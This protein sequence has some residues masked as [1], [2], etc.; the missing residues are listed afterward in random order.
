MPEHA[1][2]RCRHL[3]CS[4]YTTSKFATQR[5]LVVQDHP[6]IPVVSLEFFQTVTPAVPDI[7]LDAVL[8][9]LKEH[10]SITGSGRMRGFGKNDPKKSGRPE[11][12]T[13]AHV[14][15]LTE[16]I[17]RAGEGYTGQESCM[18]IE[19]SPNSTPSSQRGNSSRPDGFG[20][21]SMAQ[22]DDEVTDT[23]LPQLP[24]WS[25]IILAKEGKKA[26][27][28]SDA[29]DNFE[30]V[31]WSGH[32]IL[33]TDPRRNFCFG[34]TTGNATCRLWFFARSHIMVSEPFNVITNHAPLVRFILSLSFAH[35]LSPLSISCHPGRADLSTVGENPSA[36]PISG[37]SPLSAQSSQST[38]HGE[39]ATDPSH[40]CPSVNYDFAWEAHGY[41]PTM[42]QIRHGVYRICVG[43][44]WYITAGILSDSRA[45]SICGRCTRV[46][47]VYEDKKY[48]E[49]EE[50]AYY[51]LKDVWVDSSNDTEATIWMR[52][53]EKVNPDVFDRHF[54]TLV[55][56]FGPG[57]GATTC[58]FM[59]R[60]NYPHTE[61]VDF[62]DS[63][64]IDILD[65]E[66][67]PLIPN[68]GTEPVYEDRFH[69]QGAPDTEPLAKRAKERPQYLPRTHDRSIWKEVCETYHDHDDIQVMFTMLEDAVKALDA[70]W[71][72]AHAIHR[73]I[74]TGNI[75]FDGTNGRLG[76]L[77]YVV[78]CDDEPSSLHN[79]KTGT[80][81]FM[82]VEVSLGAYQFEPRPLAEDVFLSPTGVLPSRGTKPV[83]P[84]RHNV[85][86]DLESIWWLVMWSIFRYY[87]E[88]VRL[89]VQALKNQRRTYDAL[90][91]PN[92]AVGVQ[93]MN[94]LNTRL[95]AI[96][97]SLSPSFYDMGQ[98]ALRLR[99]LLI[100]SYGIAEASLPIKS[101]CQAF[102]PA[103]DTTAVLLRHMKMS[104]EKDGIAGV[105]SVFELLYPQKRKAEET[106]DIQEEAPPMKK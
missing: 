48:E 67:S 65:L 5:H 35:V 60:G 33:R 57:E 27:K 103:F 58:G 21:S 7:M 104:L 26:E 70:M 40:L 92:I 34:M 102:R 23:K 14:H 55:A 84:F 6:E 93:R 90:F 52:L 22:H 77:E 46:W 79:V 25:G 99:N 91:S 28:E 83:H 82:A 4:T 106:G 3:L 42:Q 19:H 74:S 69:I 41:D 100:F 89:E 47:R 11:N 105:T 32:H 8:D 2:R 49:G 97:S 96:I 10:G 12:D 76:D 98:L 88:N 45:E 16:A 13:F 29:L 72:G 62:M 1:P 44:T 17:I 15:E 37:V 94:V 64:F 51:V 59:R 50:K 18:T 75:L 20:R 95:P 38:I 9:N 78:F 43:D 68:K 31:M 24:S 81:P 53:K 39:V 101:D 71:E 54:L 61:N 73:D 80:L 85:L 86:H 30:K 66:P 63:Q 87:P 36:R 56:A